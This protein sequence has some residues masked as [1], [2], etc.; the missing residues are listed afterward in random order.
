MKTKF[1]L[2]YLIV[3]IS[4]INS[5]N[6]WQDIGRGGGDYDGGTARSITVT[7][8]GTIIIG[9]E[10][11]I[12]RST[13][14]GNSFWVAYN[15][16]STVLSV[17]C[18]TLS[19]YIYASLLRK[20]NQYYGIYRSANDGQSWNYVGLNGYNVENIVINKLGYIFTGVQV[21]IIMEVFLDPL[22]KVF[23]GLTFLILMLLLIVFI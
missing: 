14:N 16:P 1:L 2:A 23:H 13:D 17:V 5:Q 11:K 8:T 18:D 6:F 12:C 9:Y 20:N 22:I 10:N 7:K 21:Q 15:P 19:G 3:P 4:V